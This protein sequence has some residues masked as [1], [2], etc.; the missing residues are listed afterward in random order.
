[1]KIIPY[2]IVILVA[3]AYFIYYKDDQKIEDDTLAYIESLPSLRQIHE[4]NIIKLISKKIDS[5][6]DSKFFATKKDDQK[7]KTQKQSKKQSWILEKRVKELERAINTLDSGLDQY[8]VVRVKIFPVERLRNII[9]KHAITSKEDMK[10]VSIEN[11]NSLNVN[12]VDWT[13]GNIIKSYGEFKQINIHLADP[14]NLLSP[15]NKLILVKDTFSSLGKEELTLDKLTSSSTSIIITPVN[16]DRPNS[17]AYGSSDDE[18]HNAGFSSVSWGM[19]KEYFYRG[20]F[21]ITYA[22]RYLSGTSRI[23]TVVNLVDMYDYMHSVAS[24]ELKQAKGNLEAKKAQTIASRTYAVLKAIQARTKQ[25]S[26]RTWDLLPTTA[27]Q[28]YSGAKAEII[29]FEEAIRKTKNK[30]LVVDTKQ[31]LRPA[32]AEYFGCTNQRTL[33]DHNP[34]RLDLLVE[35]EPRNVP[36]VVDCRYARRQIRTK[37]DVIGKIL[38]Y[39]HGR[40]MCQK[41]AIHLAKNGWNDNSKQPTTKDALLPT[42]IRS[43]WKHDAILMYFY[44][45][46]KIK[47]M[48]E[49]TLASK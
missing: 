29:L 43:P 13:N 47:N 36:S 49:V 5:K 14:T 33:D 16:T 28:V 19:N 18:Y 45:K 25:F 10:F 35:Q 34:P 2:I 48:R 39:G 41:C 7:I 26:P 31:G 38:A 27:H 15:Q 30:I 46:T 6:Q 44:N 11:I 22:Y 40:G 8:N 20:S 4:S 32:F 17:I 23:W 3:L 9:S 21:D 12:E 24:T 1:M 42:D 37:K